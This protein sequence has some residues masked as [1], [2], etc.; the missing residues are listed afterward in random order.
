MHVVQ[1]VCS[2]A[3]AGVER[4]VLTVGEGIAPHE[5]VTVI[6]GDPRVFPSRLGAAGAQ[7]LPGGDRREALRSLRSVADADVVVTHM[8]D[9]D[10][11]A[12]FGAR[13]RAAIVSTRHF[14]APRGSGPVGRA[15]GTLAARR[16]SAEISISQFVADHVSGRSIVI[17]SGVARADDPPE[18]RQPAVLVMQRLEPEKRTDVAIRAW[19][20]SV[21]PA[22]G[23]RLWVAGDGAE[24]LS[25]EALAD[26][27]GVSDSVDFLGF[28]DDTAA[29]YRRASVLLAPTPHEGL[30]LAVLEAMAHGLPVVASAAGGHLETVGGVSG[31][32][33]FPPGDAVRAA[34]ELDA[35]LADEAV[36]SAYGARLRARQREEFTVDEQISR[37]LEVY[38][39]VRR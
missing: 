16:M 8:T 23:W 29:R 6:G 14:A 27:L 9:A 11:V 31:A 20:A 7:W 4:Y 10:I 39:S 32:A 24:R 26:E 21:G 17:H 15:L 25:L 13:P 28:V 38:R 18:E 33:L 36:R 30:G 2:S 22:S 3:F 35:L 37:T 12:A 5:R 34:A 1:L 19:A